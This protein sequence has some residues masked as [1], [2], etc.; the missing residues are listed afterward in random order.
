[1]HDHKQ[2]NKLEIKCVKCEFKTQEKT[3][4]ILHMETHSPINKPLGE[5]VDSRSHENSYICKWF[6]EEGVVLVIDAG[7]FMHNLLLSLHNAN[8]SLCVMFGLNVVMDIMKY[9]KTF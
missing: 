2:D 6:Q 1:M 9:V 4:F 5:K 3:K 7:I 8:L